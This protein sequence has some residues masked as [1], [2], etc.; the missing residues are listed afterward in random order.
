MR[1]ANDTAEVR[2]DRA[3]ARRLRSQLRSV[4]LVTSLLSAC[5]GCT[6]IANRSE[7]AGSWVIHED[8]SAPTN[9][10]AESIIGIRPNGTI[11]YSRAGGRGST[12]N[13]LHF[14]GDRR[15][16]SEDEE[17]EVLWSE[18]KPRSSSF[19]FQWSLR[20]T[21]ESNYILGIVR[22]TLNSDETAQYQSFSQIDTTGVTAAM[23]RCNE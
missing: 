5:V 8:G 14:A 3:L 9:G 6:S 17:I 11:D 23:S 19:L 10:A 7:L 16:V 22:I 1:R 15:K 21:G 12:Y 2:G 13:G 18:Y 20:N 4:V